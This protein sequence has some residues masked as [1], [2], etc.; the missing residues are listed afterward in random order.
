MAVKEQTRHELDLSLEICA[1]PAVVFQSFFEEGALAAWQG[2]RRAI[3]VPRLLGP[4]VL[5]WVPS[6]DA[7]EVLGRRGGVLRATVMHV[8]PNDHV[9]LADVFW[10]PP[11]TGPIGPLAIQATFK[12]TLSNSGTSAT[13]LRVAITGFDED[14]R[15]QRYHAIATAH[16]QRALRILKLLLE[17]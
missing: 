10:L 7:D 1:P 9:F 6:E 4:Y 15:S 5:D 12:A 14:V 16:W 2:I 3:A 8:E 13:L 17:K 11:D